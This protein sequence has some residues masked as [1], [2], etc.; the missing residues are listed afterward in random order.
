MIAEARRLTQM[1]GGIVSVFDPEP[2]DEIE[3]RGGAPGG[4]LSGRAT[5]LRQALER[6][7]QTE[8]SRLLDITIEP[9]ARGGSMHDSAL[10]EL[11]MSV[12]AT[13]LSFINACRIYEKLAFRIGLGR[14]TRFYDFENWAEA[15]RYIREL[16]SAVFA[17]RSDGLAVNSNRVISAVKRYAD[18]NLGGDLSLTAISRELHYNPSY[19]SRLFKQETGFNLLVYINEQRLKKALDLLKSSPE[20]V[21]AVAKSVGFDNP[22]Y[23]AKVFKNAYGLTPQEYRDG[24]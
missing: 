15:G 3:I 11:Y 20:P 6:G 17:E 18:D 4:D 23:F 8:Y 22:A 13:L 19:I 10:I 5:V 21:Y 1:G 24:S 16:S 14:L 2:P 9:L 12:A 7:D